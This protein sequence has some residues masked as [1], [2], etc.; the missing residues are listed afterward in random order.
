MASR[1]SSP[2]EQIRGLPAGRENDNDLDRALRAVEPTDLDPQVERPL[3]AL[4]EAALRADLTGVGRERFPRYLPGQP[5]NQVYRDMRI[6]AS[7][8]HRIDGA[9]VD[10]HLLWTATNPN[11]ER[12]E[13]RTAI[14]RLKYVGHSWA[15]QPSPHR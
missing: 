15:P 8:A 2:P 11:G 7:V 1:D 13:R 10:A 5:P 6:Q 9:T 4:A 12:V 3:L 14:I